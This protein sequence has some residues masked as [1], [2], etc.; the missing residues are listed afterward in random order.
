[1][2]FL[3]ES[4]PECYVDKAQIHTISLTSTL[5][6]YF[7]SVGLPLLSQDVRAK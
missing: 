4:E 3:H 7:K 1:M 5:Y 6:I 2:K